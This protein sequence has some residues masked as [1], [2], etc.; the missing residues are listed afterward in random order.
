MKFTL[1]W[2][3]EW[4]DHTAAL[5]ELSE[6]LTQIG[7]EVEEITDN[8]EALS[9]FIVAKIEEAS[10]HPNADKLQI[11]RVFDGKDT[12]QIVCGA[13][14]ARAGIH[15]VLAPIGTIIPTNGMEIKAATIRD[16]ASSGM[17]CSA[18]ELGVGVD[19]AGII[20]LD[21][22]TTTPGEKASPHMGG[23]DVLIEI[24]ITPNRGDCLGVYGIARDLAA[25]GLGTLK[26][27][28][29]PTITANAPCPVNVSI[30][31][32]TGA[33]AFLGCVINNVKNGESP[34]WLS[35]KLASI[36]QQSVNAL[37]DIT[38]L[39][40]FTF[41]RPA[42]V[43]DA[44]KLRGDIAVRFAK[45]GEAFKALNG[46][47]YR[48]KPSMVVIADDS[49]AIG[50]GGI[51]GGESTAVD[52]T[53]Q[54]VFI[55][56][57]LFNAINIAHT[58]RALQIDSDARYRFE[59][60][61]DPSF[62]AKGLL[63]ATQ[64]VVDICG[65]TPTNPVLAGKIPE[66]RTVIK[67]TPQH[68]NKRLGMQLS[69]AEIWDALKAIG[70]EVDGDNVTVPT[71]RPDITIKEDLTEEVARIVGYSS[72][73][74]TPLP[75]KAPVH[76]ESPSDKVRDV[77]IGLGFD[78]S[79]SFSFCHSVDAEKFS[80]A[81][82]VRIA[83]PIST[84]LDVLRPSILP[85]LLR[86][87]SRNQA[88]Q[89]GDVNLCEIGPVFHGKNPHEQTTLATGLRVGHAIKPNPLVAA[90]RADVYDAKADL[91]TALGC[92]MDVSNVPLSTEGVPSYY[93]PGQSGKLHLGKNVIATFGTLHPS[94]CK[95]FNVD[96]G[97]VAFEIYL[98]NVPAKKQKSHTRP[99]LTMHKMQRVE[100]DFA[101]LLD[102]SITA[103]TLLKSVRQADKKLIADVT[104]FDVYAGKHVEAGKKSVGFRIALQP[105]E[106]AFT[107][108]D[109][110]AI[111][112]KV[113]ASVV[114]QTGGILR[115][116][117]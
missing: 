5:P 76:H 87:A 8:R 46:K 20:E 49:G 44:D 66:V 38:N 113:V 60:Q 1:S 72:L 9:P 92:L 42:H 101:F 114:K 26:P 48:L 70:C 117:S 103:E 83:N 84:E 39:L 6:R 111:S 21:N 62:T 43:Y 12:H 116:G 4:L 93:H 52:E 105:L 35:A 2:L 100:R 27:L 73:P 115:D 77:L 57:A 98:D 67:T 86:A 102:E 88:R 85:N 50:L 10:R 13:P 79:V 75:P 106:A 71:Y 37:A 112:D 104:L 29:L 99:A 58:G 51:I 32:D 81:Q 16:V 11:C 59:R 56:V 68:V 107:D 94:I 82:P 55:E 47:D 96:A 91:L 23:D 78:E 90:R 89:L 80:S 45:E 54:N 61:L 22:T 24:A 19:G 53:T 110:K 15:V 74:R 95:H 25:S 97:A 18:A 109:L 65:G 28:K 40:T 7:L 69:D 17:L 41:G 36:G 3:N 33:N 34:A 14:N 63:I 108:N 30:A 31:T 64:M